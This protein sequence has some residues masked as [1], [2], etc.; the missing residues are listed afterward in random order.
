M[1]KTI[2][3]DDF[4]HIPTVIEYATLFL[5]N[6]VLTSG[7]KFI[8]FPQLLLMVVLIEKVAPYKNTYVPNWRCSL[9]ILCLLGR[10]AHF[11][12]PFTDYA[13]ILS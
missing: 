5:K 13:R 8:F 1:K 2:T 3:L 6:T 4:L 10:Y 11:S 7:F 9:Q 12:I